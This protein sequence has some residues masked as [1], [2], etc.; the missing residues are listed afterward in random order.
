[1]VDTIGL[2]DRTFVD[3]YPHAP[4]RALHVIERFKMVDGGKTCR[5]PSRR[6][7]APSICLVGIQHWRRVHPGSLIEDLCEPNNDF[8]F[9]YNVSPLPHAD[10]RTSEYQC[11]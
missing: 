11:L 6:R 8:F 7:S 4:Y 9:G 5:W 10:K 2:N 1:V 3:N